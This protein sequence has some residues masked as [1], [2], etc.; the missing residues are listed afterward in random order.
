MNRRL[1]LLVLWPS[2]AVAGV[3]AMLV[4][5]AVDP[6]DMKGY[7]ELLA[8]LSTT[9]VYTLGFLC[10]WAISAA[11]IAVALALAAPSQ[12]GDRASGRG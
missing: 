7:G 10:F 8:G 12:P 6:A 4:F 5:S 1:L 11:G 2:F 3:L 9:G